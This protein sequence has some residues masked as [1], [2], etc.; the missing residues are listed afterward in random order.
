MKKNK[1]TRLERGRNRKEVSFPAAPCKT[2]LPTHYPALL[3]EIKEK[4]LQTRLRTVMAANSALILLYWEI[5]HSI[6][7]RQEQAGWG[8]RVIDRLSHDLREVFPDMKGFSPR[9]LLFMRAFVEACPDARKVKQLVSQ[10]PWGHVIL[11]LQRV[12]EPDIR[13][14][15]IRQSIKYGWS[16]NILAIQIKTRLHERQGK[17]VNNFAVS[18]P[19]VDSDMAA[20]IFKDPYIFDFLGTADPRRMYLNAVDDLLRHP[21]DKPTIGLLLVK[22]KN[23][24]LAEYALRGY[25][26]PLGVAE[27]ESKITRSLPEELKSNL[28]SIEEIEAE[29]QN[30]LGDTDDES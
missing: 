28:P 1:E 18:L 8:A 6:L 11:L 5:G 7:Q 13:D 25:S 23:Q 17:A 2:E 16:R 4:V 27:W 24:V 22:Q 20:Q 3:Q 12:K 19:P 15:Y 29:L 30:E 14:W 26:K 9:N 10:L 21:D